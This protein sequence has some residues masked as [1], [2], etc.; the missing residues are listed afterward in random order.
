MQLM[1]FLRS[2]PSSSKRSNYS[3]HFDTPEEETSEH[4]GGAMLPI[5]LNNLQRNNDRDL[6]EVTLELDDNSFVLCS[7]KPSPEHNT[8]F[9]AGEEENSPSGFLS[10]SRYAA[11]RLRSPERDDHHRFPTLS[12]REEMKSKLKLVRNKSSAQ[13]ALGGLRF[14]RSY[15]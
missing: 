14:I 8:K 5:F 12:G 10:S 7:V 15:M 4:V 2:S 1:S 6:V 3:R 9:G 13:R 11:S